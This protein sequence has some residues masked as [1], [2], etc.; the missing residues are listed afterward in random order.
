MR[1]VIVTGGSGKAGSVVVAELLAHGYAVLNVDL[2]APREVGCLHM[3]ADLTDMGQVMEAFR[4]HPGMVDRRRGPLGDADAVVHLAGIT[5]PALLP[6]HETF[7]INTIG[8]YNVFNAATRL[9]IKRVVWASSETAFGLP[10][11]RNPP[12]F[13]PMTEAHPAVPESGY[14]L[15]KVM[16]ERMAVEMSRWCPGTVFAGLRLS[17]VFDEADYGPI[18]T[19]WDK[20]ETRMWNL[21]SWVDRRDVAQACRL[22]LEADLEGAEIFTIAA[23]DT[24]MRQTNRELMA[25][26]YPSVPLRG[27]IGAHTTLLSIDK[28]RR[29]L[30]YA[31][32]HTWRTT[33]GR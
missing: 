3:K 31:P 32:R 23:A 18:P 9:G 2:V 4:R 10:L 14:A 1:T 19:Y 21:W 28:A 27:D 30:G 5:A 20:P 6:D 7:R 13:A 24:I 17:H 15:G 29:L 8:C 16:Q 22:A 25:T 33:L 12:Q 26:Y 11:T